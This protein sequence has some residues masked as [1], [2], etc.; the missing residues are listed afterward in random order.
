MKIAKILKIFAKNIKTTP[1]GSAIKTLTTS[2]LLYSIN[3]KIEN[4]TANKTMPLNPEQ[5][6]PIFAVKPGTI[7]VGK[8]LAS[9][10]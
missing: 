4:K 3:A 10:T 5:D 8:D 7:S 6:I 2:N 1:I 9:G